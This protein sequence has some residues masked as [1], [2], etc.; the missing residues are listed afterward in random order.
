M[1]SESARTVPSFD[2]VVLDPPRTGIDPDILE[3][4]CKWAPP[5]IIY[6]SCDPQTLV[7]D[8]TLITPQNY[9][10]DSIEGFDMF[11]QTYHFETV[12]RLKRV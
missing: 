3:S 4:L 10:I 1:E 9:R 2:L 7:R 12:A 5:T 11:P 6:V 8:L